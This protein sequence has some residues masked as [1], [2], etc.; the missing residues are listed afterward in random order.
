MKNLVLFIMLIA[1][2]TWACDVCGCRVGGGLAGPELEK[3][4]H[5]VGFNY[6]YTQFKTNIDW[7]RENSS[8][9]EDYLQDEFSNDQFH[10]LD[11][12]MNFKITEYFRLAISQ[13]LKVNDVKSSDEDETL[14]GVGDPLLIVQWQPIFPS[15]GFKNEWAHYLGFATGVKA[16]L[17]SYNEVNTQGQ[18]FNENFQ[19][20]TGS[21]DIYMDAKYTLRY[22]SYGWHTQGMYLLNT[23]NDLGYKRGNQQGYQTSLLYYDWWR[24]YSYNFRMGM[25]YDHSSEDE[26]NGNIRP[27]RGG[28][29]LSVLGSSQ[30]RWDQY[31]LML[32]VQVP[33]YQEFDIDENATLEGGVTTM[34]S[35]GY[36]F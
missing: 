11:L 3:E 25:R 27:N 28:E 23:E 7:S 9:G 24:T 19:L 36:Y 34:V 21:W 32:A 30:V 33:F 22:G 20:G 1:F 18:K 8:T 13:P 10:Q 5:Y 29:S 31:T 12:N 16:P 2:E 17:G 6:S 26:I 4:S 35:A 14:Y 15:S